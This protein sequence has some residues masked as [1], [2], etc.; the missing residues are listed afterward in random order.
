MSCCRWNGGAVGRTSDLRF[1]GRLSP[2]LAPLC[3]GLRQSAYTCF[4]LSPSSITWYRSM[5][6]DALETGKVTIGQVT[7]CHI[8]ALYKST[9]TLTVTHWLYVTD[10]V[11]FPPTGLRHT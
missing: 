7:H 8:Y 6:G 4:P 9:L 5:G 11:V 3:S 2:A 1:I 10:F